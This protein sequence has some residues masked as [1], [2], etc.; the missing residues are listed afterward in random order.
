[1]RKVTHIDF[2]P[3]EPEPLSIDYYIPGAY[4]Q[5]RVKR[6]E[7]GLFLTRTTLDGYKRS[8]KYPDLI[9]AYERLV[10]SQ[11]Q[12]LLEAQ[13]AL[14]DVLKEHGVTYAN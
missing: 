3:G 5:G 14:S 4:E 2:K 6:M 13:K 8:N 10:K 9:G 12:N 7:W 1:M 11:E